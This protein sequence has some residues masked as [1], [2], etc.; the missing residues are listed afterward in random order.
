[1]D[2]VQQQFNFSAIPLGIF[3]DKTGK[4]LQ[5]FTVRQRSKEELQS[6]H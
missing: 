6:G 4:E 1:M 2:L 5:K 3:T